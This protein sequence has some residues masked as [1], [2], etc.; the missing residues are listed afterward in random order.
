MID[1]I[2]PITRKRFMHHYNMAPFSTGEAGFMRGPKRREIG[3]G[4]LAERAVLPGRAQLR[5]VPVHDPPGLRSVV[6]QRLDVD[7]VG[8]FVVAVADGRRCADQGAGRRYR[9]GPRVRRRQVHRARPTSSAPKT[10]SVTWT[11]RSPAPPTRSRR[12]NSTPRSTAFPPTCWRR[13]SSKPATPGSRSSTIMQ[14]RHRGA[15]LR[16][17]C[18]RTEDRQL[19]DPG[20]QDR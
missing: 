15:S 13:R 5:I 3:H 8:V 12:C 19:R 17:R 20:R 2:D 1:G 7:G 9:D 11:S 14:G 10:R 16:R 18:Q 6:V 4:A